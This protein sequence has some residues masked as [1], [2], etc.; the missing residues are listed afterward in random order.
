MTNPISASA[1]AKIYVVG[2]VVGVLATVAPAV[3]AALAVS[4]R[5]T[6]VA[7]SV[8][9]AI[10]TISNILAR[11]NLT[12]DDAET[13]EQSI[14]A[15]AADVKAATPAAPTVATAEPASTATATAPDQPQPTF[16]AQAAASTFAA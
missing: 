13:A 6:S 3:L 7:I 11:G 14:A 8:I 15:V 16:A 2:I 10:T 5:W 12:L 9:G 1:R 4:D